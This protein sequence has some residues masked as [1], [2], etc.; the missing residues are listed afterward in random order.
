MLAEGVSGFQFF[1][2]GRNL[3][4]RFIAYKRGGPPRL[5]PCGPWPVQLR[6]ETGLSGEQYV[7]RQAWREATLRVCPRHGEGD[8][9]FRRHGTYERKSPPGVRVARWYCRT[10][11]ETFS[12]L[13][14]CVCAHLSGTLGELETVVLAVEHAPSLWAAVDELRPDA[15]FASAI[16]WTRRR[17]RAV[18]RSLTALRGL[19]PQT[20][21]SVPATLRAFALALGIE[22]VLP[23]LRGPGAD[24]L[25][26]LPSP[27]GFYRRPRCGGEVTLSVQQPM[28]PDPPGSLF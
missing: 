2:P 9:D 19:M 3:S 15:D 22:P 14:D 17:V 4:R 28:G 26:Q 16:G 24:Y 8:C 23:A 7:K 12:R 10:A 11:H 20:F 21:A 13:P 6:Y 1:S 18:R 5:A 27:L 25:Q